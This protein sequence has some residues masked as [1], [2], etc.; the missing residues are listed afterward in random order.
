MT[1]FYR[2]IIGEL[3]TPD[4]TPINEIPEMTMEQNPNGNESNF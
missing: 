1:N 3:N 4:N 2:D